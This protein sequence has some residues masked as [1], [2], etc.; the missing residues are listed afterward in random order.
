[1]ASTSPEALRLATQPGK[2]NPKMA[3]NGPRGDRIASTAFR[4]AN[5]HPDI[6][7]ERAL[8]CFR[9]E[10]GLPTG[11]AKPLTSWATPEPHGAFPGFYEA[12]YLSAISLAFAQTGDP[13][14]LQQVN[15]MVTEL[16][17]CQEASPGKKYLF[18]SPEPEF[19]ADRLDGVVW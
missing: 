15:Y 8:Y 1:M 2:R 6:G 12:H 4:L 3:R 5:F 16:G 17:K 14:L 9:F 13:A 19:D 18:A 7:V 10:A 11:D